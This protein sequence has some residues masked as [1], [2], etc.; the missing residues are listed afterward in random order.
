MKKNA[1]VILILGICLNACTQA[2]VNSAVHKENPSIQKIESADI[3]NAPLGEHE[4]INGQPNKTTSVQS[5]DILQKTLNKQTEKQQSLGI[6]DPYRLAQ[7]PMGCQY[8]GYE[9]CNPIFDPNELGDENIDLGDGYIYAPMTRLYFPEDRLFSIR[10]S[11]SETAEISDYLGEW[12]PYLRDSTDGEIKRLDGDS[13]EIRIGSD[14]FT[15][16][17]QIVKGINYMIYFCTM[18]KVTS[19]WDTDIHPAKK[20]YDAYLKLDISLARAEKELKADSMSVTIVQDLPCLQSIPSLDYY[21]QGRAYLHTSYSPL[22]KNQNYPYT[23][24][25]FWEKHKAGK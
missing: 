3:L 23:N 24:E 5:S 13:L 4:T 14:I 22:C 8:K 12:W 7:F 1:L 2:V 11:T 10:E 9:L 6:Y 15:C 18:D 16:T 20:S 25:E 19:V 21:W 17:E